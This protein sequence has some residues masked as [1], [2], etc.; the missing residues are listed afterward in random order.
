[1]F[2]VYPTNPE[3][4]SINEYS[5]KI[6][7]DHLLKHFKNIEAVFN[8]ESDELLKLDQEEY[9]RTE[10]DYDDSNYFNGYSQ[11]L[12]E[13]EVVYLRMH[14]YTSILIAYSFL[15]SSMAKICQ[16][17]K[18]E[19]L[20]PIAAEDLKGEGISIYRKY[21]ESFCKSNFQSFNSVWSALKLLNQ[22]RNC[23]IHCSGNTTQ[24][25]N[26]AAFTKAV[27]A[28]DGLS[29][30]EDNLIMISSEYVVNSIGNISKLLMKIIEKQD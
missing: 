14:R 23:I 2:K 1:M 10:D 15:E 17:K 26:S 5:I 27:E 9:K 28:T 18:A 22:V 4:W 24:M 20:V 16:Q 19:L 3:L 29:F 13:I 6:K 30:V 7:T 12:R 11:S 25:K 8:R 21:L